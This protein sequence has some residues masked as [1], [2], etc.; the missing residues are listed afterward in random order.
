MNDNIANELI[1]EAGEIQ[2]EFHR[3][4]DKIM[5]HKKKKGICYQD[6]M[7]ICIMSKLAEII[8]RLS[9]LENKLDKQHA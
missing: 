4:C 6:A 5:N 1:D 8:I 3:M 2:M 9:K 7:N